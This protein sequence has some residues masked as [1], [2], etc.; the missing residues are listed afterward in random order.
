MACPL[1]SPMWLV[2]FICTRSAALMVC[3]AHHP[4]LS[5]AQH[6]SG[7]SIWFALLPSPLDGICGTS[8]QSVANKHIIAA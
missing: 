5:C 4:P 8:A 1:L 3:G 6:A 2:S 7:M